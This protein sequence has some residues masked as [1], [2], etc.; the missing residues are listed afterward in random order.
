[1]F[2]SI[3]VTKAARETEP[4]NAA[5][6]GADA[7]GNIEYAELAEQVKKAIQNGSGKWVRYDNEG[8]MLKGWITIEGDLAVLYHDQAGNK[9]YYDRK[10][11]LMAKGET[12]ID[13]VTYYFDEI[14]GVLK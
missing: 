8:K 10:T 4:N 6:S 1:M 3:V 2:G 11:G 9:Y 13:G 14:T 7:E 5:A 12:V